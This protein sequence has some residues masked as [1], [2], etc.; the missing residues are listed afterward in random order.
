MTRHRLIVLSVVVAAG[1]GAAALLVLL[2]LGVLYIV[3]LVINRQN[4]TVTVVAGSTPD[5]P[6][7]AGDA[8]T[9]CS[10]M[11]AFL[12]AA[13]LAPEWARQCDRNM[14]GIRSAIAA[15]AAARRR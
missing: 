8:E 2:V 10:A 11:E 7:V 5:R 15:D 6:V 9:A 4:P 14:Q 12:A 1:A 3:F 13:G